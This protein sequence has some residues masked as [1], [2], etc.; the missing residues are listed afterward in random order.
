M[1]LLSELFYQLGHLIIQ[2]RENS[3]EID[4]TYG[5]WIYDESIREYVWVE[6]EKPFPDDP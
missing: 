3:V 4:T 2:R 6:N 1:R 5:E